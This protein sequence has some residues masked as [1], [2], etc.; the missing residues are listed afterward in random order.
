MPTQPDRRA[1]SGRAYEFAVR[2][3]YTVGWA[4][5]ARL[6]AG[7]VRRLIA[8]AARRTL[9]RDGWHV[10]NLRHNLS[11]LLD[12]PAT[13]ELVRAGLASHFRN[14]YEQLALPGWGAERAAARVA[15]TGEAGL[16]HA[17]G[18]RGIV[19][20]LPHSGNWDLAGA[21]A[22][23]TGLPV[24]TVAERLGD[25][26]FRA[27]AA[28]RTGLGMEVLSHQ[29]PDALTTLG[30]ALRRRRVVCLLADRDLRRTG[31][32]VRWGGHR[33]TMPAGPALLAQRTGAALL[34]TVSQFTSEG[35]ALHIGPV[36]PTAP[37]AD[38]VA[39]MTQSVA[40]FFV[41][42]LREQPEDW[43]MLQPFFDRSEATH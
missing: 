3:L 28:F 31:V 34:P 23:H 19:V 16:R 26:E 27:F 21:W 11:A 32:P 9:E 29:Q 30:D 22:C 40:D 24:T 12:R 8:A 14:V 18:S 1:S 35:M 33:L 36:V 38:G 2:S 13:D 10:H 5:G 20:A 39:T 25:A 6:P 43:H 7:G 17:Y 42:A 41:A 37:G 15:T 4:V